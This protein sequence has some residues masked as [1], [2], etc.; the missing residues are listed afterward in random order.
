M[1][2]WTARGGLVHRLPSKAVTA[3]WALVVFAPVLFLAA[4]SAAGALADPRLL[5]LAVPAGRRLGLMVNT[6][7]LSAAVALSAAAVGLFA[8]SALWEWDRGPWSRVRWIPLALAPVPPYIHA[9]S[10]MTA[11]DLLGIP[12]V[13]WVPTFLVEFMA[14]LPLALG[15]SLVGFMGVDA[16]LVEAARLS[17]PDG[18]VF[19]RVVVP[20]VAPALVA[21]AGLVFAFTAAD[22]SV[23]T[24][25][26]V[27]V[28]SLE[29]FSDFSATNQ[30]ARSMLLSMP[31]LLVTL[32]VLWVSQSGLRSV[33]QRESS[34]RPAPRLTYPLWL[35]ALRHLGLGVAGAQALVL[36]VT[37]VSAS[38]SPGSL[39]YA[40]SSARG[41]I[42]FTVLQ[43]A[44]TAALCVP[45]ALVA[46]SRLSR[47]G[48]AWWLAALAPLAVPSPLVG[49]S[50]L[51]L[52][53]ASGLL[54]GSWLTPVW[55]TLVR[56]TP[57]A[58][59]VALAQ[60][61][62]LDPQLFD[63][64][65]VYGRTSRHSWLG[66]KLPLQAAG[67]AASAALVF[68][69]TVGEMGST[70]LTVPPGSS[71][72]TIRVFNYLHYGGSDVVA[73]LCL[74]MAAAMAASG[75]IGLALFSQ[76]S[77]EGGG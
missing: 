25:F 18:D 4:E 34:S 54:Y 51:R 67:L 72:I 27:N 13:G 70:L 59:L 11:L 56:F 23:P 68:A 62:R 20:L 77:R 55:G 66:V 53:G 32:L 63:A 30:A 31:I 17:R 39:A 44:A 45:L 42:A 50:V 29:V 47:G 46:G 60:L 36:L 15:L 73:G 33:V 64:A 41:D 10:W 49:I 9:L 57:V 58:C 19:T 7:G 61:K 43:A 52:A 22:Y 24:L 76:R 8:G 5:A 14:Y 71:T 6:L 26:S 16:Q 69:F 65:D 37:L 1:A 2:S 40:V 38:G 75:L 3:V 48:S 28:Y 12:A 35:G 74:V 21:A